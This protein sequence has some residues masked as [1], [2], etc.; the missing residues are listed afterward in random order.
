[1]ENENTVS[2]LDQIKEKSAAGF[3]VHESGLS[4]EIT[5]EER[6]MVGEI[7]GEK[8]VYFFDPNTMA[9]RYASIMVN[10]EEKNYLA[11][12]AETIRNDSRTYPRTTPLALF[13][14]SSFSFTQETVEIILRSFQ[15]KPGFEDI[16]KCGA[17]NGAMH[18][19]FKKISRSRTG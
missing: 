16:E 1:M 5:E 14:E 4:A 2:A 6:S 15:D 9:P 7:K 17:S 13:S 3:V 12:A 8:G 10:L 19:F 11:L 18:L